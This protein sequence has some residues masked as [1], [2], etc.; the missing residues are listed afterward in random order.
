MSCFGELLVQTERQNDFDIIY[1]K[2]S[3]I[4]KTKINQKIITTL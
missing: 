3:Y 1:L 4:K 2:K